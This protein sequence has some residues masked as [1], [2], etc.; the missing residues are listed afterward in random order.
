MVG[1]FNES[2]KCNLKLYV[3]FKIYEIFY[4]FVENNS[5]KISNIIHILIKISAKLKIGNQSKTFIKSLTHHK[6]ILSIKF[7]IAHANTNIT[8]RF[9]I[10]FFEYN[11]ISKIIIPIVNNIV[12]NCGIGSDRDIPVLNA[13]WIIFKLF[14]KFWL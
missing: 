7:Q 10:L 5:F 4:F 6:N 3:W 12:I 14:N 11:I 13:G 2:D 1:S 9:D 8:T